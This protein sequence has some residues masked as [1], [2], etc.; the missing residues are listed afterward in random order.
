MFPLLE[1]R[2]CT[3]AFFF[4]NPFISPLFYYHSS[5]YIY[6][7]I[8]GPRICIYSLYKQVRDC[9]PEDLVVVGCAT[10]MSCHTLQCH[11]MSCTTC[12]ARPWLM[13]QGNPHG[14]A[15][16]HNFMPSRLCKQGPASGPL[17]GA[18]CHAVCDAKQS[19]S[20]VHQ[21]APSAPSACAC[22]SRSRA[23][24]GSSDSLPW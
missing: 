14:G 22:G 9:K 6:I 20:F 15:G 7:Y 10:V 19:V 8:L 5:S 11:V 13:A 18:H 21:G 12:V 17:L 1:K 23:A 3:N 24:A 2:I 4:S 16:Q